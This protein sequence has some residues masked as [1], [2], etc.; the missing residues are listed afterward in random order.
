MTPS[1]MVTA[2]RHRVASPASRLS[3][4]DHTAASPFKYVGCAQTSEMYVLATLD[5]PV[6]SGS[7]S[8]LSARAMATVDEPPEV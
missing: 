2:S 1:D 6:L 5:L 4:T 3:A 8:L 7:A